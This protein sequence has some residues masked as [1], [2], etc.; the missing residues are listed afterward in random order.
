MTL[1][2]SPLI[3]TSALNEI[4]DDPDLRLID[5]SWH[6]DARDAAAEFGQVRIPGARFLDLETVSD[7]DSDL[8]HMLVDE[9]TFGERLGALGVRAQ[10]QIVVYDA[11]GLFSA[12]RVWW[13]LKSMG[14]THVKV[15]DGGLPKWLA[16][17]RPLDRSDPAQTARPATFE[18][19]F[20]NEALA[21]LDDVRA[22]LGTGVQV[23][24]ARGRPR[25]SGAA[26]DPRPGVRPG[27]MPGSLNLPYS[28]LISENGELKSGQA[29]Q[30][31]FAKAGLDLSRPVI[32]T[33]GSGVTA[34]IISLALETIAKPSKLYDGSWS[35]WGR[36]TDTPVAVSS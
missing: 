14:A 32:T 26:P 29:L 11:A 28:E 19:Q 7:P 5:G 3:S 21:Q 35:E 18:A 24:D 9:A 10:D 20:D 13:M 31:A 12:A 22:A 4:L 2:S 16:E 6:L 27:H 8:P 23:V 30:D 33:C 17:E 34:A 1:Q 15:L 25:F 36:R